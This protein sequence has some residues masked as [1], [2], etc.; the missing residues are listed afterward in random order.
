MI[1]NTNNNF[2]NLK[3]KYSLVKY[4]IIIF[5]KRKISIVLNDNQK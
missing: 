4:N 3:N 2:Y 1:N 5:I